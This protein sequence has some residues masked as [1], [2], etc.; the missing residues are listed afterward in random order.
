VVA[1]EGNLPPLFYR[2]NRHGSPGAVLLIQVRIGTIISLLYVFL[3]FVNQAFWLLPA[4]T[5]ELLGIVYFLVFAAVI[6]LR[7]SAPATPRAF[8]IP[9]GLTGVWIVGGIGAFRVIFTFIIGL[10]PPGLIGYSGVGYVLAVLA[11]TLLLAVPPLIFI[12]LKKPGW[13]EGE[14]TG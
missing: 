8:T 6:K 14:M 1:R 10:I 13:L 7:Y 12:R 5:V 2:H 4:M 9:G 3:P 11:G